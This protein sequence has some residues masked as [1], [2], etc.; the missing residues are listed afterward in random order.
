MILNRF[1]YLH[2]IVKISFQLWRDEDI[3][4]QFNL[5]SSPLPFYVF[6]L[7]TLQNYHCFFTCSIDFKFT[8]RISIHIQAP[9]SIA[10]C[11][12]S[13]CTRMRRWFSN[14]SNLKLILTYKTNFGSPVSGVLC[15]NYRCLSMIEVIININ[16][17]TNEQDKHGFHVVDGSAGYNV[18]AKN[19][20]AA[21]S[22]GHGNL[23]PG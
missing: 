1:V 9:R 10:Q 21:S 18:S 23:R 19:A 13:V 8:I 15:S 7:Y 22:D 14:R 4:D 6:S 12:A 5:P 16:R 17:V 11:I 3:N 20:D 2:K